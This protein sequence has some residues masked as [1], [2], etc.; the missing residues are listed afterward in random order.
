[1]FH[2]NKS[3]L[4]NNNI[5]N[6]MKWRSG[7]WSLFK[8]N[9]PT[10]TLYRQ[11][12]SPAN[13]QVDSEHALSETI[14]QWCGAVCWH[15]SRCLGGHRIL[16]DNIDFD[17]V[18]II[19]GTLYSKCIWLF[20]S[21]YVMLIAALPEKPK[22]LEITGITYV[23]ILGQTSLGWVIFSH[24]IFQTRRHLWVSFR[25]IIKNFY[26]FC[27]VHGFWSSGKFAL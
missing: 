18:L 6:H 24:K 13:Q 27:I 1:M 5:P 19:M 11:D 16:L 12:H 17:T 2:C 26:C 23:H 22:L 15:V 3:L 4:A 10:Y 9:T 14:S 7:K 20:L 21:V 8:W 25:P